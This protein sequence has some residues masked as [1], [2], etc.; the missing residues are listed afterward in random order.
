LDLSKL[1]RLRIGQLGVARE[2]LSNGA[3]EDLKPFV[4][5]GAKIH[6]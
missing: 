1:L 5:G 6:H 3:V 4:S 2:L